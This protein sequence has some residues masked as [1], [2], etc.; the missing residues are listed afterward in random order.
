MA[1]RILDLK[2]LATINT[3]THGA[4]GESETVDELDFY[5]FAEL[6]VQ[7]CVNVLDKAQW[8]IGKDWKCADGTRI[9]EKIK[10]HFGVE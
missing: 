7:E 8:D 5:K 9:I 10:E 2:K 3:T 4:F 6:I 1:D